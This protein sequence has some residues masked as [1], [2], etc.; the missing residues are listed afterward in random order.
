[1]LELGA[2]IG[3]GLTVGLAALGASIGNG[4]VIGRAI[5]GIARNPE[6]KGSIT[7]TM[8]IG[9]GLIEGLPIIAV[10]VAFLLMGKAA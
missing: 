5:E 9:V 8:F 7:P 2:Y 3:A 1:M 6:A 4:N 10:V